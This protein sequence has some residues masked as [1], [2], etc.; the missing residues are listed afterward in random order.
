MI[1]SESIT[2]IREKALEGKSAYA[3]G[4]ELGISKNT[5]KKYMKQGSDRPEYAHRCSKLDP[6]KPEIN[7]LMESGIFNCVTILERISELGYDG[8]ISIIKEY[9]RPLRP[10]KNIPAVRRYETLP[11]RQAQMDWGICQYV[12]AKGTVHKVPAFIMILGYSRMRYVEFT[13]R[14]DL[15]SL[16]H[17]IL[18]AFEY[19][20]GVPETVLTDNMKTVINGRE[21]GKPIWNAAFLDF[22]NDTGF[23]PKVCRVRRPETKGKVERLVN[24]VKGSFIPGREFTDIIDLNRQAL[25][26]CSSVNAKASCTTGETAYQMLSDEPLAPLPDPVIMDRYRYESRL[27]SRDCFISYDGVRYGV[28]WE[29]SGRNVTVRAG[30]GRIEIFDG[31]Q[32]IAAHDIEPRSGRIIFLPGQYRGLAERH[33][34]TFLPS[35]RQMDGNDVEKRSLSVYEGLLEVSNG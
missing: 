20:G 12:D 13:K 14:C 11:G 27:V 26:W 28:P 10:P 9:V 1:R 8:R 22:C 31:L 7:R 17:C 21:S 32:L 2:M 6:F 34:M 3:I 18:D 30:K 35:A 16:E 25:L 23:V 19:F 5:V 15:F 29:Y 33:G 24:Y 4:K